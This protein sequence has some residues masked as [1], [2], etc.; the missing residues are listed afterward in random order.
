VGGWWWGGLWGWGRVISGR[1]GA[2]TGATVTR[3]LNHVCGLEGGQ[4]ALISE[5]N[6][7]Q[8][9]AGRIVDRVGHGRERWLA[10][11]LARTVVR[12]I[13]PVRI[14]I[15]IHQYDIDSGRCVQ[16]CERGMGQPI[17]ACDLFGV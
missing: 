3:S 14:R 5:R 6:A 16:M 12:E 9:N 10:D 1:G 2:G 7:T 11:G 8:T 13:R 15:S 4:H 17:G